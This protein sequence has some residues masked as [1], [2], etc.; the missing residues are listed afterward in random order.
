[1]QIII[2][3]VGGEG[4]LADFIGSRSSSSVYST[5]LP[6]GFYHGS[7]ALEKTDLND[8]AI[9]APS[10]TPVE[11]CQEYQKMRTIFD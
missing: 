3:H 4:A 11:Y 1:M 6:G 5:A 2:V 8:E 10:T 9:S 7:F